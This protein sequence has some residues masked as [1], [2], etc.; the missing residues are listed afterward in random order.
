MKNY[1][2]FLFVLVSF[3]TI[4]HGQTL[5]DCKNP[6]GYTYYHHNLDKNKKIEFE[7]DRISGGMLS[8]Q[9]IGDKSYDLLVVDSRKK[10]TSMTQDGG[11][12]L[13]LR[14][15]ETDATFLLMFP[16]SSIEIYTLWLDGNGNSRLDMLQSRGGDETLLTAHKSALLTA[17]CERINFNLLS[18]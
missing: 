4:S 7:K 8:I 12:F 17:N 13:L 3:N 1:L 11:K 18:N 6:E 9:K 5:A 14:K 2:Y 10:I 16:G 15:G